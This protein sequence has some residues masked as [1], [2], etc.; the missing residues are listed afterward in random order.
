MECISAYAFLKSI[1]QEPSKS[2]IQKALSAAGL[3]V[4]EESITCFLSKTEGRS[5]EEIIAAGSA[6]MTS[7]KAV[8]A[9]AAAETKKAEAKKVEESEES[10]EGVL[11]DDF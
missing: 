3:S 9:P 8:A 6:Q 2:N 7:Q 1:N 5:F 11:D 10:S 4:E